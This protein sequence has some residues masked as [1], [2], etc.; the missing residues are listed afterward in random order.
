MVK[1]KQSLKE[2]EWEE[3][4]RVLKEL[5]EEDCENWYIIHTYSGYEDKAVSAIMSKMRAQNLHNYIK[6]I[7]V[8]KEPVE[9]VKKG[10][11]EIV[12]KRIYPGYVLIKMIVEDEV[13][14]NKIWNIVKKV[15]GISG[16]VGPSGHPVKITK[17]EV[18]EIFKH[19][20]G[21]A[22]H[23]RPALEFE[24]GET[25]RIVKGPFAEFVGK[26]EEIDEE[27][28]KLKLMVDIFGRSTPLEVEFT[29]V[30]KL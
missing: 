1:E 8:P 26:I 20:Q 29:E 27:K 13:V 5:E 15:P 2:K 7:I 28:G 17:K 30:E 25:V 23:A 11:K 19:I 21:R 10:K 16:F 3:H 14:R 22:S 4:Q 12:F 18:Q 24:V 6:K 9:E